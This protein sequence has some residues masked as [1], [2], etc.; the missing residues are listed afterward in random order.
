MKKLTIIFVVSILSLFLMWTL[1]GAIRY[2]T[3]L[4]N[5]HLDL[6][7][8]FRYLIPGDETEKEHV[9][10]NITFLDLIEALERIKY[11]T[12]QDIIYDSPDKMTFDDFFLWIKVG[13]LGADEVIKYFLPTGYIVLD[14]I[15]GVI[16]FVFYPVFY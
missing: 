14:T 13:M 15:R 10:M 11:T 16:K 2:G 3:D 5:K 1:S 6:E 8:T 12:M 4:P 9:F 7:A